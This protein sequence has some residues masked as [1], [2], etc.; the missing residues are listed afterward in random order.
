MVSDPLFPPR[1]TPR[2]TPYSHPRG[3]ASTRRKTTF[4]RTELRTWGGSRYGSNLTPPFPPALLP[5]PPLLLLRLLSHDDLA[6]PIPG[7]L[8]QPASVA[9]AIAG[10]LGHVGDATP[11]ATRG[12]L[13]HDSADGDATAVSLPLHPPSPLLF[14]PRQPFLFLL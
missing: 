3:N 6:L 12:Q 5:R 14:S 8:G 1:F 13:G 10:L 2:F 4:G 11:V 7:F 9:P